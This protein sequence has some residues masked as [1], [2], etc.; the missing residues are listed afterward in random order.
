MTKNSPFFS[1]FAGLYNS[2][3][4]IHRLFQSITCQTFK[5][6]EL[7]IIDDASQDS[8]E[9]LMREAPKKREG[10]VEVKKIL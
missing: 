7:I 10:Y 1:I 9:E 3:A 4:V 6:F 8:T 5:D 2:E